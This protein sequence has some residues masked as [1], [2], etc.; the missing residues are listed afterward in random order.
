MATATVSRNDIYLSVLAGKAIT[1]LADL[2]DAPSVYDERIER[3][4]R[5]GIAYCQAIRAQRG[6]IL[7]RSPLGG[8]NALKR[9]VGNAPEGSSASADISTE[10]ERVERFLS[11]LVSSKGRT[12]E[13][14][15][16]VAAIDFL[17]K[18]A[19]DR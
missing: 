12:A 16:L 1:A 18:T 13:M 7:G 3:D 5:G 10:A 19:A 11:E 14:A 9:S 2:A 8:W 15:G 4:L 17:G 6:R